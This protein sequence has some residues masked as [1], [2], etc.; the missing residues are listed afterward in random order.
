[1]TKILAGT[2]DLRS[3]TGLRSSANRK[4]QDPETALEGMQLKAFHGLCGAAGQLS[5][6]VLP[7]LPE[8][9]LNQVL[10]L[11]ESESVVI[12]ITL[13]VA[14]FMRRFRKLKAERRHS[15]MLAMLAPWDEVSWNNNSPVLGGLYDTP[16]QAHAA[17]QEVYVRSGACHFGPGG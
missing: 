14:L 1:M 17:L 11:L 2:Q 8:D 10:G 9:E 13:K 3:V 16:Q 5:P 4:L 15:S 6:K 7:T 12:P